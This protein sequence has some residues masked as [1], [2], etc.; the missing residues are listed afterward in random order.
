MLQCTNPGISRLLICSVDEIK[1][2]DQAMSDIA[3]RTQR[4]ACNFARMME[5]VSGGME[6]DAVSSQELAQAARSCRTCCETELCE[7]WL[8]QARPSERRAPGF[9][10]NTFGV[11]S[12][13]AA[14]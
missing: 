4:N 14:E 12:R 1:P 6:M 8:D 5:H 9:C 13:V 7:G 10:P 11:W 3:S 2:R